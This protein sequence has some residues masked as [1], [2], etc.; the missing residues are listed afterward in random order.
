ME[1]K[2]V[3]PVVG[4]GDK[5]HIITRRLFHEDL[6]RHFV[7]EVVG[8]SGGLYE[9]RGFAFILNPGTGEYRRREVARNRV[10]SL[11]DSGHIASK[12]PRDTRIEKVE[13][14]TVENRLV[15][16]DNASFQMDINEF[17]PG[18]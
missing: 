3:V 16:T 12:L 11:S 17:G 15:V 13:Y 7:G 4:L 9:L 8:A 18:R 1:E 14:K 2:I 10:F 5:L 6:R